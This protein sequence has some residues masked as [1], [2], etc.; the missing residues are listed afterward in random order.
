MDNAVGPIFRPCE[1]LERVIRA[2]V[3]DNPDQQ[4]DIVDRGAY[5]R[6]Q[7][8]RF[9]RLTLSSLRRH[10]GRSFALRQLEAMMP[11]FAGRIGT[12]SDQITWSLAS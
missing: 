11:S 2:I 3:D 9:L 8:P 4:V 6:V 10:V 7:A 5:V 12:T 1:E